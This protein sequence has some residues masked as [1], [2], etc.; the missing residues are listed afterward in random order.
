MLLNLFRCFSLSLLLPT[1]FAHSLSLDN[2]HQNSFGQAKEYAAKI[3][4]DAPG[5]F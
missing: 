4:A 2:Y 1:F 5:S 3:N